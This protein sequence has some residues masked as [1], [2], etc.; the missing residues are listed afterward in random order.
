MCGIAGTIGQEWSDQQFH[1]LCE[2]IR[3]RGPDGS[4]WCQHGQLKLGMNRLRIR[5]DD[6]PL[7]MR[8]A[9]AVAGFN[10]QIYGFIE[11]DGSYIDLPDGI[12]DELA[13]VITRCDMV[14]GMFAAAISS[15]DG[16]K[17]LLTTDHHF[18]KPMF[19][20]RGGSGIAFC[21]E[22]S[23]LLRLKDR[24]PIDRNRLAEL[25]AY[26]W[27]L[28]DQSCVPDIFS[29]C[30]HDVAFADGLLCQL[31]KSR[32]QRSEGRA[33]SD[34]RVAVRDSALRCAAGP[35]PFGLALSG[36][37]DSTILAWELNQAGI[38]DLTTLSVRTPDEHDGI[39]SLQALGFAPGGAWENWRHRVITFADDQD[40]LS[41]FETSV[42]QFGQPTTMSSLPLYWKLSELA[43]GEGLRVVITG[44]GVDEYFCGY[45][46]Y[47]KVAALAH[48]LDYYRHPSREQLVRILFEGGEID[49]ASQRLWQRYSDTTD[50]RT[51]ERELRLMR[52]LLRTDVCFMAFSMEGRVPFLHNRIPA[53]ALSIPW[54]EHV[55]SPG[56]A[57][58]RRAYGADLGQRAWI[59]KTRFKASDA[60]L[61]RLLASAAMQNRIIDAVSPIFSRVAVGRCIKDLE[62]DAGFDADICCLLMSLTFLVEGGLIG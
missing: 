27:Y 21:S 2:A 22:F 15:N 58:L 4:G 33:T 26:G 48:P 59:A 12:D 53:L 49:A 45:G 5:G 20:R 19:L 28:G 7:P 11:N 34:L 54:Q 32:N 6:V 9:G 57:V 39:E 25:F 35:G 23:P 16:A 41:T 46:S 10:G 29:L 51:V 61:R 13:A 62:T 52:L 8:H 43:A 31:P 56:K 24:N 3:H 38:D 30:G 17:V 47:A 36:G 37:L 44:E 1:M 42:R 55:V 60:V 14:D 50:L 18:I 40:F